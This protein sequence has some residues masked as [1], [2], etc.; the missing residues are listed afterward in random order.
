MKGELYVNLT[1]RAL[2]VVLVGRRRLGLLPLAP[3]G[4][5]WTTG[6]GVCIGTDF[7]KGIRMKTYLMLGLALIGLGTVGLIYGGINYTSKKNVV[8]LGS[9]EL[10]GGQ[11]NQTAIPPILGGFAVVVGAALVFTERRGMP[12][13]RGLQDNDISFNR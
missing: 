13:G 3:V 10:P 12:G 4:S 11:K 2:G 8:E 9:V 1:D 7:G 5:R 6:W